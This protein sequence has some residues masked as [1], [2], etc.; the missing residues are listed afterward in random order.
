MSYTTI[1]RPTD[2][3]RCKTY[4]G[5][6]SSHAITY[7]ESENMQPDMVWV[8]RRDSATAWHLHDS[9]RGATKM[10]KSNSSD[11]ETTDAQKMTSFDTNGFTVG[12]NG[13]ANNSSGTFAS[14]SWKAGT[15]ISGTTGGS[16]TSKSYSGSVNTTAGFSIVAFEGNGTAGHTVPH[17]LNS[18]PDVVLV[19]RRNQGG[20]RVMGLSVVGFNKFLEFDL[21]G[22]EQTS[23][24][25]FN[26]TAPT[27]SVFT[28]GS[29]LDTNANGINM[30]AWCFHNVQGYSKFGKYFG[31]EDSSNPS[32]IYL[33][34]RPAF[35]LVKKLTGSTDSWFLIDD[36]RD[37]FNEDNEY[38]RP[39]ETSAEGSGVNR[40]NIFSN[41]FNVPTTDKSHNA[42]GVPYIYWAF[43]RH[44]FVTS[45]GIPT[46][47]R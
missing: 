24:L 4:S 8:K 35:V 46:C 12:T 20:Q 14:W 43:A 19:T 7:T 30:I 6:G 10:L 15:S 5:T 1:D 45:S 2:Y 9:V 44:P 38:L 37:G 17:G 21:T 40:L 34:F 18:A 28:L 39:N 29:T 22:S 31:N 3:F 33:G 47:A 27:S 16:G 26:D 32:F 41:G 25:R 36:L 11:A 13:D 42:D 23:T